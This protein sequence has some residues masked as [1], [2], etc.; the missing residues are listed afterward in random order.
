MPTVREASGS[1]HVDTHNKERGSERVDEVGTLTGI[2]DVVDTAPIIGHA[3][4]TDDVQ[5]F[6]IV[7]K[8]GKND[9]VGTSF[10]PI[11]LG[12]VYQMPQVANATKLRVK[13]GNVNDAAAGSGAQKVYIIGLDTTGAQVS[14]ELVTAGTSAG[15]DSTNTYVRLF[16]AWVSESGSYPTS[17]ANTTHAATIVIENA[18]GGTNWLIINALMAQSH[19]GAYTIP[20]GKTGYI[21]SF[22]STVDSNKAHDLLVYRRNNILQTAAPY[23]GMRS[24]LHIVGLKDPLVPNIVVPIG[25]FAALTDLVWAAKVGTGTASISIDFEILLKDD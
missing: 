2:T 11:C 5:E 19:V 25:P 23:S 4:I 10:V 15:A 20:L 6:S 12:G 16:R 1:G 13:A 22:F 17:V 24:R 9:T 3:E 8:F 21:N 7:H 14:E 18:A